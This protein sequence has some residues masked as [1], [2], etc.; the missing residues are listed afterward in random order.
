MRLICPQ[1]YSFF[2]N[3]FSY[4]RKNVCGETLKNLLSVTTGGVFVS[5]MGLSP[6]TKTLDTESLPRVPFRASSRAVPVNAACR[7]G[8]QNV[9]CWSSWHAALAITPRRFCAGISP[10]LL[11]RH[12][13][14]LLSACSSIKNG[15]CNELIINADSI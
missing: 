12:A 15:L 10:F 9:L 13:I 5:G 14:L 3:I 7:D 2:W 6:D 1:S 11:S 4:C 8:Q